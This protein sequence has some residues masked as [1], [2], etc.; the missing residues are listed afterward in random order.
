M[1]LLDVEITCLM[2]TFIETLPNGV[3]HLT[4]YKQNG[5][6]KNYQI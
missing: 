4:S 6:L 1:K 2:N 3:K 5:T